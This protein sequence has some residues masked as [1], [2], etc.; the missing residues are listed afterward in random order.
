MHIR[1]YI[2]L[3][4]VHTVTLWEIVGQNLWGRVDDNVSR[5]CFLIWSFAVDWTGL[6]LHIHRQGVAEWNYLQFWVRVETVYV[7]LRTVH[8]LEIMKQLSGACMCV[9]VCLCVCMH[10]SVCVCVCV[11]V[12]MCVCAYVRACT[13]R[14]VCAWVHGPSHVTL[15]VYGCGACGLLS[16][17]IVLC[18]HYVAC[19]LTLGNTPFT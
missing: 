1:L 11:S 13:R 19:V 6:T 7:R 3:C 10:V 9:C 15:Y 5:R 16:Y 17:P 2:I 18:G 14:C 12:S 8:S 4:Y